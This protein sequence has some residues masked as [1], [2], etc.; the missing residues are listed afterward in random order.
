MSNI[1]V[2]IDG[3]AGSGKSSICKIVAYK[4][5]FTHIDTGAMFR[6]VTLYALRNNLDLTCDDSYDFIDKLELKYVD[7]KIYLNG[8]D[9]S[10]E[11][12]SSL[13]TKNVSQVSK[14]PKVRTKMLDLERQLASVGNILMDGRDIGT[15][16]LPNADVKIFLTASVEARAQRRY[17]EL[18][19][20]G[21]DVDFNS[22]L[23][24]IKTRDLKDSTREIAPLKQADDAIL[25]DTT[26][27]TIDEVCDNIIKIVKSKVG[28]NMG[29]EEKE[30]TSMDDVEFGK[31][32]RKGQIVK[33]KVIAVED[34][35]CFLDLKDFTEGKIYLNHFT[36][37]KTQTSLQ[38]L[39]S[40]GDEIEAEITGI[41]E[42][43]NDGEI[44]CSRLKLLRAEKF[45]SLVPFVE[46]KEPIK[47][48]VSSK[49][50]DNKGYHVD[51]EGIELF[52][53]QS[54]APRNV[55]I[56]DEIEG[57]LLEV[58][59]QKN[60]AIFSSRAYETTML[61]ENKNAELANIHEGDVLEGTV[62]KILPF[63]CFIKFNYVQ[64]M[65]RLAE[66]SHTYINKIEDVLKVGDKVQVKV[67]SI[68][69]GKLVVSRKA[70]LPT[71][72]NEYVNN[73]KVG[74]KIEA[75]VISKLPYGILLE[76]A[77][78][79]KGLLHQ[80]EYSWNPNDNYSAYVK[81]DDVIEVIISKIDLENERISLSRKAMLD[82]PWSRVKA[83]VGDI[84]DCKVTEIT[85]DGL[86][87]E[88]LGVDGIIP[89]NAVLDK[90]TKG[91]LEDFYAVGDEVKAII[92]EIKP[93]EWLLRL[94]IR[95][96]KSLEERKEMEKYLD[97]NRNDSNVTLG[98]MF[99]DILK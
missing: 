12:R 3:P 74:E 85:E 48:K 91:K 52:M 53:P 94:S 67:L 5:N 18:K 38:H 42:G 8:E 99:K 44:L 83:K 33:G 41:K 88:T 9:V 95:R 45:N 17:D 63:A 72:F 34:N 28:N 89:T 57:I 25:V 77:P 97:D 90:D 98:D 80:S 37:D 27:M 32:L 31:R 2:A 1:Q 73:H 6:A 70:I 62:V 26:N 46:N 36:L 56:G 50:K 76:L 60:R 7:N 19:S 49:V 66:I 22:I 30:I 71:P 75:K 47:V 79:V 21:Q 87:V 16:V 29:L 20:K 65:L 11:I 10:V 84:C 96:L 55:N 64:A 15:V 35:V 40:V 61:E 78:S 23:E 43:D 68:K 54:Q 14:M 39:V 59:P 4:L 58:N 13:V 92:T 69:N 24:D 82:N 51:Y 81:I 86:K 93:K